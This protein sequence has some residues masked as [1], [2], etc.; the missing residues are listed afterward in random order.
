MS[1][2]KD[3]TLKEVFDFVTTDDPKDVH[4]MPV[5]L[6]T[7]QDKRARLLIIIEG[8]AN[9]AHHIMA[10]LMTSVQDMH[11]LAEQKNSEKYVSP[12]GDPRIVGISGDV[13]DSDGPDLKI[14]P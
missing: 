13:L 4:V 10:N 7:K 1:I 3:S 9:T 11:D 12:T 6:T 2:S 14:V 5:T 8:S